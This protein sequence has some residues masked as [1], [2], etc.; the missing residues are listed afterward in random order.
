MGSFALCKEGNVPKLMLYTNFSMCEIIYETAKIDIFHKKRSNFGAKTVEG[1]NCKMKKI[2]GIML[3]LLIA[4]E[5]CGMSIYAVENS[6][7]DIRNH[8][9]E[10]SIKRWSEYDIVQGSNGEFDP[11]GQLTCA[12]LATI[13]ARLLKLPAAPD[14]GFTDNPSNAWYYDA[15]NRCAAGGILKGNGD[16]TV[17]PNAPIS[18][19][20]AMVMLSRALGIEPLDSINLSEFSDATLV[21]PYAQGYIA[22]LIK[23]GIV[24]GVTA[25]RLA[26]QEN[27]T[28]AA[29]VTVLDRA[30]S[31]YAN[32]NGKEIDA[33]NAAGII[34]IV[35][36]NVKIINAP[37]GV[38]VIVADGADHATVNGISMV[39]GS[40]YVVKEKESKPVSGGSG[41]STS[42]GSSSGGNVPS[43][44]YAIS[45]LHFE[46][47]GDDYVLAWNGTGRDSFYYNV[48]LKLS[49]DSDWSYKG[50]T[51][52]AKFKMDMLHSSKGVKVEAY[53]NESDETPAAVAENLSLEVNVTQVKSELDTLSAIFTK[54][55]NQY[56]SAFANLPANKFTVVLLQAGDIVDSYG[57]I[58]DKTGNVSFLIPSDENDLVEN[59]TYTIYSYDNY[60][61][62]GNQLSYT[63]YQHCEPT[64]CIPRSYTLSNIRFEKAQNGDE[65]YLVWDSSVT[66]G[67]F[68]KLYTTNGGTTWSPQGYLYECKEKMQMLFSGNGFRVDLYKIGEDAEPITS[69][70]NLNISFDATKVSNNL[71]NLS[72]I[73]RE[74]GNH[75]NAEFSGLLPETQFAM[76]INGTD[77][78]HEMFL[79]NSDAQ[80]NATLEINSGFNGLIESGKYTIYSFGNYALDADENRL[81]YTVYQLCEP[82]PCNTASHYIRNIQFQQDED[83]YELTWYGPQ[84]DQVYYRVSTR[85]SEEENWVYSGYVSGTTSARKSVRMDRLY[86][87]VGFRIEAYLQNGETSSLVASVENENLSCTTTHSSTP[88]GNLSVAFEKVVDHYTIRLSGLESDENILLHITN[89]AVTYQFETFHIQADAQGCA[90]IESQDDNDLIEH[91]VYI[92]YMCS[93]YVLNG[94]QLSYNVY[95]YCNPTPCT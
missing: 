65:Y 39:G 12:Q 54:E 6:Y 14:A 27:N 45:N 37:N 15:I 43:P 5:L 91:G 31:I 24:G 40:S 26:P 9:A 89:P 81:S 53:I 36:E 74:N 79:I 52:D 2:F 87:S 63:I 48:Y 56:T 94:N 58:A 55:K 64:Y 73:F 30:I 13:L 77:S 84:D 93:G 3:S 17:T 21:S 42:G 4:L 82:T 80:G 44:S 11:D 10:S 22:A 78:N 92:V 72:V 85:S 69:A 28:R 19:E 76:H 67:V 41:G 61:L 16:G 59:G 29:T 62:N 83:A 86:D 49:D 38:K 33:S 47:S 18:R 66:D 50:A 23:A 20:R 35:A 34:L 25:D 7:T 68:Y 8:W 32:E 51:Q 75:Y 70:E 46:Q 90:F 71:N 95:E 1:R 57:Q 60:V 88:K